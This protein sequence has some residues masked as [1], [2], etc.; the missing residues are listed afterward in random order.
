MA[1]LVASVLLIGV[2]VQAQDTSSGVLLTA[3]DLKKLVEP[4]LL[5]AGKCEV[6]GGWCANL[7]VRSGVLYRMYTDNSGNGGPDKGKWRLEDGK[8]WVTLFVGGEQCAHWYRL[9]D[10]SYEGRLVPG[11]KLQATFR[12]IN[13]S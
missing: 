2:S 12:T 8:F 3:E 13:K 4:S 1:V 5:I 10:G 11:E 9:A 6:F 7:F